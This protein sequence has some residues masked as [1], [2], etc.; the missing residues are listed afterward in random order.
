MC[1]LF[2]LL[3]ILM[4]YN[5][6][7]NMSMYKKFNFVNIFLKFKIYLETAFMLDQ[8]LSLSQLNNVL[9]VW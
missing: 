2:V 7:L 4:L 1:N 6:L 8:D 5:F 9:R 3:L